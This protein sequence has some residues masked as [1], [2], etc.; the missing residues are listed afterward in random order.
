MDGLGDMEL[1]ITVLVKPNS[2]TESVTENQD[3]SFTVKV[4]APPVDGK[5]N[6]RVVELLSKHFKRPKS[7]FELF[8]GASGKKKIFRMMD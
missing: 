2:R 4:N 1:K 3:G 7:H 8:R 5:A 6:E